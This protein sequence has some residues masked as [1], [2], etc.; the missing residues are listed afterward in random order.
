MFVRLEDVHVFYVS[1]FGR[2]DH[3]R[4]QQIC[5]IVLPLQGMLKGT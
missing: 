4:E 1:A 5:A 2:V 3:L